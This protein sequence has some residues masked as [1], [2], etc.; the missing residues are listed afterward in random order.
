MNVELVGNDG[1][2]FVI[3]GDVINKSNYDCIFCRSIFDCLFDAIRQAGD[4]RRRVVTVISRLDRV[5]ARKLGYLLIGWMVWILA[6]SIGF[7][8][9]LLFTSNGKHIS[10]RIYSHSLGRNKRPQTFTFKK[11]FLL[12]LGGRVMTLTVRGKSKNFLFFP[13]CLLI[14]Y[15]PV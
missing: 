9:K 12:R 2:V 3:F 10:K 15:R 13:Y 11:G 14:L 7:Q 4:K 6:N 8:V 5:V 1:K